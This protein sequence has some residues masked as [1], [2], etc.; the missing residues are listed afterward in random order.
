MYMVVILLL[1]VIWLRSLYVY[2]CNSLL[3]RLCVFGFPLY[4]YIYGHYS[5][6]EWLCH[7]SF[8]GEQIQVT[9]HDEEQLQYS[10]TRHYLILYLRC[11]NIC[12]HLPAVVV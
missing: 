9:I 6:L 11:R 4:V 3:I 1:E 10:H 5:F 8:N 7:Y 2:G 12:M